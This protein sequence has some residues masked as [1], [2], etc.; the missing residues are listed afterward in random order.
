MIA[1]YAINAIANKLFAPKTKSS[2]PTYTFGTLQTQ[3]SS[4]LPMP[5]IYGTVKCAGNEIWA[6][7]AGTIQHKIISF[8][9]GKIKGFKDVRIDDLV[10]NTCPAFKISNT[11]YSDA[12]VR[13]SGNYFYLKSNSVTTTYDLTVYT[14]I[15]SLVNAIKTKDYT[16]IAQDTEWV[17]ADTT[18]SSNTTSSMNDIAETSCYNS[19]TSLIINGLTGCSYMAYVGDGEQLIDDRVTGATQEDKAKLVG[20]LKYDAYLA[21]TATASDKISS[22]NVTAVVEGR[23]VRVYNSL[24]TYTEVWSDNPAWC[25]LDFKTSIDGCGMD[26]SSLD[27]QT[28]LTAANYFNVLIDGR[29]RFTVNLIL[30][31]KKTRQDWITEF[32]STCRSYPTYQRGLHGILVDKPESVSQR[33]NVKPDESIETWWQDNSEDVERLQVEYV[34]PDYE[35]TKVVA[36]ADR[37]KLTG[38]TSQFRNKIPLTKKISI[39]GIN[40]FEQA[41]TEAWFHLNK[42]QTCPEWIQY[43]TN[44]RALNRSIGDVVGVWNPITE[45]VED[46][47][48]YKRYRI[49]TM[50]EP[51]EN[52]ITMVMQEYNPNLYGFT[53]GSVAPIINVVKSS[54]L[55]YTAV[56]SFSFAQSTASTIWTVD[57]PLKKY[58][59]V[60]VKRT[61]GVDITGNVS[62]VSKYQLIITFSTAISGTAY[63]N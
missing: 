5:I 63:L 11:L 42:A 59:S 17:F 25:E 7:D 20:G 26:H 1:S 52:H 58:P 56:T 24:T 48:T 33:F 29:K 36:Q 43:T 2:S 19:P 53:M 51:Q 32:F 30:D 37:V 44:K 12:T 9:I 10:V 34:A 39:Y 8:G 54:K 22:F 15:L 3:T 60:S 41:S 28:Y 55:T 16:S 35:Y 18:F 21:I 13:K 61:D 46:G 57:H 27:L 4:S 6:S 40:N 50:T 14:T 45:V 23:I 31:E 49:M 38:E 62:Y 47:L